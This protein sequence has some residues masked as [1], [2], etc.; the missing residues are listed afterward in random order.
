MT[1][2]P[3]TNDRADVYK[4]FLADG[5]QVGL[6]LAGDP[7]S[8]VV[9]GLDFSQPVVF[10]VLSANGYGNS[11][12]ATTNAVGGVTTELVSVSTSK[13]KGNG[14]SDDS[15]LSA[16]GRFV[17]FQSTASN[18]VAG[19]TNGVSDVFVHDR[20]TET[21]TRVSV[22]SSGV[23][24]NG[25]SVD[26]AISADGRYVV[27]P[28]M[29]TNLV[30]GDRNNRRDIF[31]YDRG[32]STI[33]RVSL[34]SSGAQSNH[35]SDEAVISADGR[36]VA[37]RSTATNLVSGDTNGK[38]DIFRKDTVTGTT[39][40]VSVSTAGVQANN[41]SD[42]P[43]ISDDGSRIAF[44]SDATNLVTG[45]TNVVRDAFVRDV[46]AGTT[47]RVSVTA[48]GTQGNGPSE[49]ATISGDGTVA[50]F[51]SDAT[52]LIAD[53]TNAHKDVFARVLA[54]G[55]IE[56]VSVSTG[57][58]AGNHGSR[59][60]SLSRDGRYVAFDTAAS[61]FAPGESSSALDLYVRD[62]L[63]GT[64]TLISVLL[65]GSTPGNAQSLNPSISADGSTVAF[66]SDATNLVADDPNALR[67]VFVRGPAL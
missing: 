30:S 45:D 22:S 14:A 63:A 34:S 13:A 18:L 56:R 19:D 62:R 39:I 3:A 11:A 32:S 24:G 33:S 31:V 50:A 15:Y 35:T 51:E 43:Q 26:P 17:T 28:S 61:N 47:V 4:V 8:A 21:T 29:A 6:T 12:A 66:E 48:D 23:Q 53:D 58:V 1:W 9:S 5:T 40:L 54:T 65:C 37:F 59:E 49:D 10:K 25:A 46:T 41:V 64:T 57:G 42:D 16:D 2:T 60:A 55:A 52:N 38:Q 44:H 20:L 27:F 67:D 7:H 36:Y